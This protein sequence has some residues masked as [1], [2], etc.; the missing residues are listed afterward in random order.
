MEK[1]RGKDNEI[2]KI[3]IAGKSKVIYCLPTNR[4]IEYEA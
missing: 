3:T 1:K 4:R 2:K